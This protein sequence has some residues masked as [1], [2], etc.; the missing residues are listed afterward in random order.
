MFGVG[1][2]PYKSV[3]RCAV[4]LAPL[5][6]RASDG[7]GSPPD[8]LMGQASVNVTI[9]FPS[10]LEGKDVTLDAFNSE[11]KRLELASWQDDT[12]TDEK[13]GERTRNYGFSGAAAKD[14]T[15]VELKARDYEWVT[16]KG[17]HLYPDG[18]QI[19]P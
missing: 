15:S 16:F 9:R 7:S 2:G 1:A 11:G 13:T 10:Q 5:F 17:I 12:Q 14:I 4:G 8:T 3:V 6:G 18:S 19:K